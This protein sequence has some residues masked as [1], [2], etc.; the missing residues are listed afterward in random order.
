M[1]TVLFLV[2][3]LLLA[4]CSTNLQQSVSYELTED[5]LTYLALGDSYTIGE[6]VL[7]SERW[8]LQLADAIGKNNQQ[9]KTEIIATTGWRTDQLLLAAEKQLAARKFDLVSLL[10]GVNNEYQ[11]EKSSR[12]EPKFRSCLNQAISHSVSGK[13]GVF[14]LSIPDYGFTPFGKPNQ[15]KISDR[16]KS[17]NAIC[18]SVCASENI[19]FIDIT[20]ISQKGLLKPNLVA[21]DGLHPSGIQYKLWVELMLT[22]VTRLITTQ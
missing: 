20:L 7:E 1:K 18:K 21:F 15:K 3:F 9:F 6:S 16:I 8:P 4:S 14:V 22:S 17:Y 2:S 11:G 19:L 13:N 10:I 5:K 12:F